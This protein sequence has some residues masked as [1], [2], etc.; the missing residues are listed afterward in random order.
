[1]LGHAVPGEV[2]CPHDDSRVSTLNCRDL[3]HSLCIARARIHPHAVAC[4]RVGPRLI[5]RGPTVLKEAANDALRTVDAIPPM[6]S[7]EFGSS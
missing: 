2:R 1:M 5:I 6:T 3:R 4:T 7:A